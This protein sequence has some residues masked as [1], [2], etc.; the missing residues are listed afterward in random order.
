M[1]TD[2]VVA[3]TVPRPITIGEVGRVSKAVPQAHG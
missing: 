2:L 3:V 1:A